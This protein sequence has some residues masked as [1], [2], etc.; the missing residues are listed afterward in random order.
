[1]K[2]RS[3]P[4]FAPDCS[5]WVVVLGVPGDK[6]LEGLAKWKG[7]CTVILG[8][9]HTSNED[10][11]DQKLLGGNVIFLSYSQQTEINHPFVRH[12]LSY[13]ATNPVQ[14]MARRNIG[15][16]FAVS[17]GA[18]VVYDFDSTLDDELLEHVLPFG[19]TEAK[20]SRVMVRYSKELQHNRRNDDDELLTFNPHVP[21]SDS[22]LYDLDFGSIDYSSVGVVQSVG[23]MKSTGSL[24]GVSPTKPPLL[25]PAS[26]YSPY[27]SKAT[28]HMYSAFWGLLLP[29][30]VPEQ[31]A[32]LWRAYWTQ[33]F[34]HEYNLALL[35]DP[36]TIGSLDDVHMGHE[37]STQDDPWLQKIPALLRFLT[38]AE[39]SVNHNPSDRGNDYLPSRIEM[40]AIQLYERGFIGLQDVYSLQEW[41]LALIDAGYDFPTRKSTESLTPESPSALA[42]TPEP[43]LEG[44][45][46][47]ASPSYNVG[48]NG[49]RY[50]DHIAKSKTA[51]TYELFDEWR[52]QIKAERRTDEHTIFKMITMTKNEWPLL[53][54][55]VVYHG[56][57][58]GF[59]NL[60]IVDGSTDKE[61]IAF[62]AHAR[63]HFG[64]NV[65]F[66]SAGLDRLEAQLS[67]LA[68]H[69]SKASDFVV[70]FDVDEF[71][72]THKE[73]A[74]CQH[75]P[76]VVVAN[77][78]SVDCSLS[79][80]GVPDKVQGLRHISNGERLKFG[81][82]S[83]S[84]PNLAVCSNQGAKSSVGAFPLGPAEA[85]DVFKAISDSRTLTGVDLG[86]HKNYFAAP[87]GVSKQVGNRTDLGVLHFHSRC[88]DVEVENCRKAVVSHNFIEESDS[89]ET[90]KEKLLEQHG[91]LNRSDVEVCNITKLDGYSGHKVL[92]Y[93]QYLHGCVTNEN[94]YGSLQT[95]SYNPD[96]QHFLES[97][98]QRHG[99]FPQHYL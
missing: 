57:L 49:R 51:G 41:L 43:F 77:F 69:I 20:R 72:V 38:S 73:D 66:S 2:D 1:M 7:W 85:I 12:A 36:S 75:G 18:K 70:K 33:I 32:D 25:A 8:D 40:L 24:T 78:S 60:Y 16:L 3:F 29:S 64:V 26:K 23:V 88:L 42:V 98:S 28:V 50:M 93:L 99:N 63:D 80:Y 27:T 91:L 4:R 67:Q 6:A 31:L 82:R 17:H 15:Y 21:T 34:L 96:F 44:Q 53:R 79:P 11:L 54:D 52:Q 59:E 39:R 19:S 87:F 37:S 45:P 30:T 97:A 92:F 5:R 90:A 61:S 22:S 89:E 95:T 14:H 13:M 55:W 86:G 76:N 46:Y 84:I 48:R 81:F 94:F 58:I 10:T 47:W 68:R 83:E 65:V 62:L 56:E 35:F 71:L 74:T 9:N